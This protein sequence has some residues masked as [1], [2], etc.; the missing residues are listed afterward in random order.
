MDT[1]QKQ[2]NSHG[3]MK[4]IYLALL[5]SNIIYLAVIHIILADREP[6][7]I[8]EGIDLIFSV[9]GFGLCFMGMLAHR[10]L[11]KPERV[12]RTANPAQS[13]FVAY[14]ISWSLFEACTVF[15]VVISFLSAD[16][17]RI[18]PFVGV[19]F[20]AFLSHPPSKARRKRLLHQ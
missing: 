16:P 15:G 13:L 4:M 18:Y 14:I 20:L 3:V 10:A 11:L 1:A 6:V 19:A 5:A 7:V 2:L 8:D 17:A 9:A 12:K